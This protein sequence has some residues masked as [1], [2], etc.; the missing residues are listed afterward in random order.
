[1]MECEPRASAEVDSV[2]LPLLTDEVPNVVPPS[3]KV[4][5]PVAAPG[6]TV[7]VI[8]TDVPATTGFCDEETVVVVGV[9]T[10]TIP[11]AP[12]L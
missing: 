11:D 1:M 5:V 4:T 12:A 7:A 6:E 9:S 3:M 10:G 2:A 8:V